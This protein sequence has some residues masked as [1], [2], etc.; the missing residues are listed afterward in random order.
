MIERIIEKGNRYVLAADENNI[1]AVK[2]YKK[3]GFIQKDKNKYDEILFIK[4]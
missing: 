2:L 1:S 3:L 4:N